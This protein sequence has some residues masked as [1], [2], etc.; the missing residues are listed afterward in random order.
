MKPSHDKRLDLLLE[1]VGSGLD[2]DTF[3]KQHDLAPGLLDDWLASER[4]RLA[5]RRRAHPVEPE[6]GESPGPPPEPIRLRIDHRFSVNFA[7]LPPVDYVAALL[8]S[9]GEMR[10]SYKVWDGDLDVEL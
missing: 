10:G 3:S 1:Y 9:I 2:S 5:E 6:A 8:R 4:R 7:D